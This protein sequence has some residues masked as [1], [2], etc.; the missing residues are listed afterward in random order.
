MEKSFAYGPDAVASSF[1]FAKAALAGGSV[2]AYAHILLPAGEAVGSELVI[3]PSLISWR[4]MESDGVSVSDVRSLIEDG[5]TPS[6]KFFL[7]G[8]WEE[9]RLLRVRLSGAGVLVTGL[10]EFYGL[11]NLYFPSVDEQ[12]ALVGAFR[13]LDG[14]SNDGIAEGQWGAD[15]NWNAGADEWADALAAATHVS[16]LRQDT[17]FPLDLTSVEGITGVGSE[18]EVTSPADESFRIRLVVCGNLVQEL[19]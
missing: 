6:D 3:G 1:E 15:L 4:G 10:E 8:D 18:F 14:E 13:A 2:K 9:R 16:R 11:P 17:G 5:V 12:A 19:R 7:P